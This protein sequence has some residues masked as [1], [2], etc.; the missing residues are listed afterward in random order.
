MIIK[1]LEKT[2]D[3]PKKYKLTPKE[4]ENLNRSV[5]RED[6]GKVKAIQY[7]NRRTFLSFFFS[8]SFFVFFPFLG[9]LPGHMEV[10]RLGVE[11]EL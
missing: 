6:T 11:S 7:R 10:P 2:V 8:F 5:I 3:L 9:P 1:S 4:T